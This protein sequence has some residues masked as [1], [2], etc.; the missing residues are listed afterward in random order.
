MLTAP[1]QQ[2]PPWPS[3]GK[4]ERAVR[5]D[6][7]PIAAFAGILVVLAIGIWA[8]WSTTID[9]AFI[10][11]RYAL[12][13]ADGVGPTWNPGADPVEGFTNFAWM[14]W[15]VPFAAL[16]VPLPLVS[17][18]TSALCAAATAW[19]LLREP[20]TRTGKA[21]AVGAYLLFLPTYLHVVAGLETAAFALVL[22]RVVV[23]GV[24]VL[25]GVG[26]RAWELP[27]LLLVGGMLRPEGA[28][29]VVPA[30][31]VW[32]WTTRSDR[33]TWLWTGGAAVVGAV[34]FLW[35]WSYY[36]QLLPN[37]FYVK[38][39]HLA[40]GQ[41]WLEV[42]C[43]ALLPLIVLAASLA[44]RRD[45]WRPGVLISV[46]VGLTYVTY[47]LSGPS[48]DYLHRFAFHAVP[49]LCLA[50]GFA[51]DTVM[52]RRLA[53]VVGAVAVGWTAL[54]GVTAND[55]RVIVN[56][57]VDLDRAHAAIG[58]GLAD[59]DLPVPARTLATSDAGAIPYYSDWQA[60]DYIGLNDEA[61]ARGAS[62]TDVVGA[63]RPTVVVVTSTNPVPPVTAYGL[64]V[65]AA[66]RGYEQVAAVQ[67]REDYWQ[68]VY[69]EPEWAPRLRPA[70][71]AE[72][73]RSD[74]RADGRYDETYSRWLARL[75]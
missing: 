53:A 3:R 61:I 32:A 23:L 55:A 65:P 69:A 59:A 70:I 64:D 29:A 60:I 68:L 33:R 46:T 30:L 37:T 15:H 74:S 24:R 40:A 27:V 48:M 35:R 56:Y 20:A 19:M 4:R 12:H 63:E 57:G 47:A 11:Y 58:R 44:L 1:E 41:R 5:R 66:T 39:G 2:S 22:L 7:L 50:A 52:P 25:R 38:F 67:M 10:T 49:V 18:L 8:T 6:R 26:V 45:A 73:A 9:D 13:A 62:P 43:A 14:A 71:A 75:F 34:Y 28:V 21:T 54:A 36:G 31:A 42:T 72:Q 51:L 16:G 17:K